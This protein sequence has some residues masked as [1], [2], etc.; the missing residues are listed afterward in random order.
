MPKRHIYNSN[1]FT[2]IKIDKLPG[3]NKNLINDEKNDPHCLL[4][5]KLYRTNLHNCILI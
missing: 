5:K 2:I 3:P 4:K 1:E